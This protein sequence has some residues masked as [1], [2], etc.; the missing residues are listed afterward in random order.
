MQ[1]L[2]DS[3]EGGL[4]SGAATVVL[5][6]AAACR[7]ARWRQRRRHRHEQFSRLMSLNGC[8]ARKRC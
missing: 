6:G 7:Q 1:P 3:L 4:R 5:G 8:A 2:R